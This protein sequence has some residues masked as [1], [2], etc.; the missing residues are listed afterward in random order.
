[1]RHLNQL[2]A[3]LD[4]QGFYSNV[5]VGLDMVAVMVIDHDSATDLVDM[6]SGETA[7]LGWSIA[8]AIKQQVLLILWIEG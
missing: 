3:W 7:N 5:L 8:P 4:K 6:I 1:M 2:T